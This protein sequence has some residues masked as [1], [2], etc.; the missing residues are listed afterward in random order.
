MS[1]TPICPGRRGGHNRWSDRIRSFDLLR[2]PPQLRESARAL[3]VAMERHPIQSS[4]SNLLEVDRNGQRASRFKSPRIITVSPSWPPTCAKW[5]QMRTMRTTM[6][7]I[8]IATILAGQAPSPAVSENADAVIRESFK[9]VLVRAAVTDKSG[10]IINGLQP[11]DFRLSDN[12]SPQTITSDV[13]LHPVSV[14]VAIQTTAG[15]ERVLPDV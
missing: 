13:A 7:F 3:T 8:F 5:S 6:L 12:G 1:E 2:S 10:H 4:K 11:G 15:V 9:F 14:V